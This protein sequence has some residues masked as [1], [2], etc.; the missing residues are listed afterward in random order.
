MLQ[1]LSMDMKGIDK[2]DMTSWDSSNIHLYD[3]IDGKVKEKRLCY[4]KELCDINMYPNADDELKAH[5]EN[6]MRTIEKC[7]ELGM[8]VTEES[9]DSTLLNAIPSTYVVISCA[10]ATSNMSNLTGFIFDLELM[11][12]SGILR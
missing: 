8:E 9:V 4:I 1:L 6:F 12:I 7:R 5:L 3:S 10:E 2:Y 11:V